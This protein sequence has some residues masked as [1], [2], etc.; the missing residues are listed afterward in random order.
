MHRIGVVTGTR[1]EYGLLK[2]LIEKIDADDD[3]SLCLIVTG[4]HLEERLGY[5]CREIEKDG[6]F[7]SYKVP[8][9]L[10]SD[11]PKGICRSMG[12]EMSELAGILEQEKLDLLFLLGDRYETFIAA[13]AAMLFCVP[14]AHLHGGEVT[15]GAIDDAIRHSISK[16]S[17]IHFTSTEL[18]ARRLRQMGEPP[19]RIFCVGALGVENI[20][21]AVY[22]SREE[23]CRRYHP[24]FDKPYI[25]V[26]YHPVTLDGNTGSPPQALFEELLQVLSLNPAYHYVFTYAS[27]DA[28]GDGIN[29]R[30]NSFVEKN[31][32]TC[33]F[34]SMGQRGYLSALK[35]AACVAGNSSSGILEAPSFHIPTVNIGDRQKG[36]E[37]AGSVISCGNSREEIRRAFAYA[38]SGDFADKCKN[39][40]NPYEGKDTSSNII[41]ITKQMLGKGITLRK[42]FAD[43]L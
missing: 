41:R 31:I 17:A 9:H 28:G 18:S 32:N 22:Y 24:L 23:L 8:M 14:I 15:E 7:I 19:E 36:R 42:T 39:C 38:L 34:Q 21:N 11:Q 1:A 13:A 5:T 43:M 3:L 4:A 40:E 16:M 10:V 12:V 33:A 27:A 35:Y 25:L 30:I 2:P 26:T 37:C 20:K 6:F 29:Q